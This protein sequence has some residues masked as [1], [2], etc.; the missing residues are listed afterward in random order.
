MKK[1]KRNLYFLIIIIIMFSFGIGYSYLNTSLFINVT[2]IVN[3]N[4]WDV[5]L[6]NLNVTTGSVAAIKEASIDTNDSTSF[7][8]EVKLEDEDDFYEFTIDVVNKGNVD[9]KLGSLVEVS[10]LT[11]EQENYFDHTIM[12]ENKEFKS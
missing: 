7:E 3:A 1:K 11:A 8:F 12:Y 10:S 5:S 4:V 6:D 2:S 9:A